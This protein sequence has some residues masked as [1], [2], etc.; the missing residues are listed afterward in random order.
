MICDGC[1][2]EARSLTP[3]KWPDGSTRGA[4][5]ISCKNWLAKGNR[6]APVV[7][8]HSGRKVL[9]EGSRITR[10]Y[11]SDTTGEFFQLSRNVKTGE[12]SFFVA[13][14]PC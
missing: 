6:G 7:M 4:F 14:G 11:R 1:E 8:I 10:I 9:G 5:C 12:S 13:Y 2:G 3:M